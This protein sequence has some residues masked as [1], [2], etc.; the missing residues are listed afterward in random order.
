M[1]FYLPMVFG[2]GLDPWGI[3][4]LIPRGEVMRPSLALETRVAQGFARMT[5]SMFGAGVVVLFLGLTIAIWRTRKIFGEIHDVTKSMLKAAEHTALSSSEIAQASEDLARRTEKQA[6]QLQE[7]AAS[8]EEL[9]TSA[10]QTASHADEVMQV[11]GEVDK[12]VGEAEK[13][14][15][16]HCGNNASPKKKATKRCRKP[17]AR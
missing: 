16:K 8:V 17:W 10:E 6:Q 3:F 7:V 2:P 5:W 14:T 9:S 4:F 11:I 15:A 12:G 13:E 1:I